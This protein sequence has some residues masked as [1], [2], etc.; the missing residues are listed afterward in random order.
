VTNNYLRFEISTYEDKRIDDAKASFLNIQRQNTRGWGSFD[1]EIVGLKNRIKNVDPKSPVYPIFSKSLNLECPICIV[2]NGPSLNSLIPFIKENTGSIIIFS[3]GT[4][5]KPL[6][7]HGINPD[8][9]IEIERRDHVAGVLNEAPLGETTLLAADIVDPSTLKAAKKSLLFIRAASTS[10]TMNSPRKYIEFANPVVGNAAFALALEIS[11]NVLLCG[12]DVGF[13]SDGK[14]HASGSYYDKLNDESAEKIP[15]RGNFSNNIYTNSLF[16]LSR[17]MFEHA[18]ASKKEVSVYNL[19]DGAYINGAMPKRAQDMTLKKLDKKK[20]LKEIEKAFMQK[21][22]FKETDKDY[23]SILNSYLEDFFSVLKSK[24]VKT[25]RDLFETIDS[26]YYA[27]T[28]QNR[29]ENV[30]G[31]LLSGTLWHILN[32]LFTSFMHIHDDDISALFKRVV[33]MT[34]KSLKKEIAKER[35]FG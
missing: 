16:S 21:N 10:A 19:S 2:G 35:V 28:I 6:K 14:Q 22:V 29:V 17:E 18:I 3:S 25:R 4:A 27:T 24:Q 23:G 20:V 32:A 8:F 34:E 30:T 1:D 15:T 9:Q 26:A 13:K 31:I 7:S 33:E 11:K 12:L 5:L